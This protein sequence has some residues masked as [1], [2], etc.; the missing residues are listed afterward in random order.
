M[1]LKCR[2]KQR[3]PRG[4]VDVEEDACVSGVRAVAGMGGA[5][6]AQLSRGPARAERGPHSPA[7]L[8]RGARICARRQERHRGTAQEQG[9]PLQFPE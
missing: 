6:G 7:H 4:A 9:A 2:A 3:P 1:E 8:V 5:A